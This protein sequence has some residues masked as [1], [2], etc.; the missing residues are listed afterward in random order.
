MVLFDGSDWFLC[1]AGLTEPYEEQTT[2]EVLAVPVR[3]FELLAAP[4]R[5]ALARPQ[6]GM[7]PNE[8]AAGSG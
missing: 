5:G 1:L 4:H 6:E 8:V 7:E 2:R 3:T